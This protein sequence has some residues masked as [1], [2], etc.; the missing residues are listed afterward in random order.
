MCGCVVVREVGW[1]CEGG[2]SRLVGVVGDE[3][4]GIG[5]GSDHTAG[6]VLAERSLTVSLQ[7]ERRDTAMG[8]C[9]ICI[10]EQSQVERR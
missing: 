2:H 6:G 4:G 7:M 10:L 8:L 5:S 1:V 3:E 9:F